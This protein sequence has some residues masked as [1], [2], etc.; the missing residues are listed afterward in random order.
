MGGS[1]NEGEC[2]E[3]GLLLKL[4]L[5][6]TSKQVYLILYFSITIIFCLTMFQ[7]S[8]CTLVH[9]DALKRGLSKL[10]IAGLL[11]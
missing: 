3:L 10:F 6:R 7:I 11:F 5:K 8:V 1:R 2:L 4:H 9:S